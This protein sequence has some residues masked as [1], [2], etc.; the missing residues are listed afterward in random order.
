MLAS[1]AL[2]GFQ[3]GD[4]A[5][6]FG[7]FPPSLA[8]GLAALEVLERDNLLQA[9]A[10]LGKYATDGLLEMQPRHRLIGDVRGPGLLI[11]IELVRDRQTREPAAA[12]AA[13]GGAAGQGPRRPLRHDQVRGPG[14]RPEDQAAV[15]H[16]HGPDRPG[17]GRAR[18]GP[19]R[20]RGPE[21]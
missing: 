15:H 5:L 6:T 10:E 9:C 4:D 11:G 16:H 14:Q 21:F 7:E 17:P 3:P 18:P 1:S 8:A 19:D 20:R 13:G 2:D 12:E